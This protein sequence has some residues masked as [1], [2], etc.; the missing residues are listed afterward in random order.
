MTDLELSAFAEQVAYDARRILGAG[1]SATVLDHY[2]REA[3]LDLWMT[4]PKVT[5]AVAELVLQ[6]VRQVLASGACATVPRA[7]AA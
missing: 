4:G 3:V 1:A 2:A 7:V 5:L 6:Q